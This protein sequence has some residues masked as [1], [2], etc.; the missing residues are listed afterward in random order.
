MSNRCVKPHAV[1]PGLRPGYDIPATGICWNRGQIVEMTYDWSQ[2]SWVIARAKSVAAR[3]YVMFKT[4]RTGL[5]TRLQRS[6]DQNN[7]ESL[8]NHR[9]DV[10]M[11]AEVVGDRKGQISRST[12]DGRV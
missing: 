11:V 6:C 12:V 7:L 5:T 8:T 3:S 4:S 10:P 9:K 2:R 1:T